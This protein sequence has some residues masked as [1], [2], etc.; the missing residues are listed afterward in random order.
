MSKQTND[1]LFNLRHSAEHVLTQAMQNL[2]GKNSFH[3]AMGP[4]T[5]QGFYF[6]FENLKDFKISEQDFPKIEKEMQKIIDQNLKFTKK[7]INLKKAKELFKN[8]PYKQEWLSQIGDRDEKILTYWTADQ[9]V[10]LCAGPHVKSTGE[11]KAFKLL[12]IAGAY[13]HGDEKNK[14]LTRIYGT[15]FPSKKELKQYLHNLEE[16]KKRDH[17]KLGKELELFMFDEEVGQGLPL[18]LPKGAWLR[19]KVMDF[20]FDTYLKQGYQPVWSPHFASNKLWQHSGHLEF[21]KESL[22]GEFTVENEKYRLKPMNCPFHVSIYNNKP[23]SYKE[24]PI[25]LAEMGT[26]YR[27]EKSG[28]LH[29]LTRVRG[30]TQDDAHIICTPKQLPSEIEKA[31][32]LTLFIFKTFGFKN[33]ELNLSIRDPKNKDKFI[34][35]DNNWK[36]AEKVLK[37]VIKKVGYIN[38]YVEDIGGAVFYGPKIDLKVADSLGRKWQLS[39]I[40]FDFNLPKRFNMVYTGQDG[41]EHTP[42]MIHRALLGSLERFIGVLIEHFAGAFPVWLS[43]VQAKI[44]PI[45]DKQIDYAKKVAKQLKEKDIR[46]ELDD[47]S[48]TMQN[49]IRLAQTEKAPYMLIIGQREVDSNS[50][51]IRQRNGQDLGSMPLEKFIKEIS[52]QISQKSLNLIK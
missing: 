25:R 6:D 33:F 43:P 51:S 35:S 28:V 47:R 49:K 31:F 44:I 37:N 12:S 30:F 11:I 16:A 18:W 42:Y 50:V 46:V 32:E 7:E 8:N 39:T 5:D 27:Y 15:A 10:D 24:L 3:M 2:F 22:Y 52:T 29:G 14:M 20:A 48:E 45:T 34:G 9:F 38:D 13:W 41:Q 21:Y 4:A 26:V 17:R 36:T 40:Q 23:K 1:P 19:K